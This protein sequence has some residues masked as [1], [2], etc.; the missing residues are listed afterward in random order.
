M[1]F[2][3]TDPQQRATLLRIVFDRLKSAG[4][5]NPPASLDLSWE[6]LEQETIRRFGG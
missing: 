2:E 6:A 5:F 1:L 4:R 3:A